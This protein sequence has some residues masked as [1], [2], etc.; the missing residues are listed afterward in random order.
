MFL[1]L[2]EFEVKSGC[3]ARFESVYGAQGDWVGL[4]RTD[5]NFLETRLLRDAAQ[6]GKYITLDFWAS[7]SAYEEFK[8]LNHTAY[9]LIDKNCETLT[10]FERCLGMFDS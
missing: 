4:F 7:R 9:S 5:P 8:E 10:N 1:A 3:E 2:W 6:P